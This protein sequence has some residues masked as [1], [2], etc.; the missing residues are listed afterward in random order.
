MPAKDKNY[1]KKYYQNNKE[2]ALSRAKDAYEK[3]KKLLTP[4]EKIKHNEHQRQ[5]Y[6]DNKEKILARGKS[7]QKRWYQ[8]NKERI[9]Q[10][11]KE[12][13]QQMLGTIEYRYKR[14]IQTAKQRQIS[15]SLSLEQYSEV[16]TQPCF[17]CD[18]LFCD[19]VLEGSGLDRI[20]SD[21]GYDPH[22]IVSC[23]W[24]CNKIKMDDLTVEEA[25]V[26][27]QAIVKMRMV[28]EHDKAEK[29]KAS[30]TS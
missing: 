21:K 4:E 25:K 30:P 22:N 20:D 17:Y 19:P 1:N 23:G 10:E 28:K 24:R 6:Q 11:R 26:A 29:E 2:K 14:A 13:R 16:A 7:C 18:N 9:L 12:W 3:K 5:Y 15:F 8:N 27:I